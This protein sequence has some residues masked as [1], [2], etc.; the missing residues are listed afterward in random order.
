MIGSNIHLTLTPSTAKMNIYTPS[1]WH[2]LVSGSWSIFHASTRSLFNEL[3]KD[4]LM[5]SSIGSIFIWIRMFRNI[6][7]DTWICGS[8][9]MMF[10]L[11]RAS[12][13]SVLSFCSMILLLFEL[14]VLGETARLPFDF[15]ERG[16][17]SLN[18]LFLLEVACRKRGD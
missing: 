6:G 16:Y 7:N 12:L 17:E 3:D 18:N 4:P 11:I 10:R 13:N 14:I 1:I 9:W 2:V 5:Q 15:G 8:S